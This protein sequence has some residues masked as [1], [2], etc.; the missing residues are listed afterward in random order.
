[1]IT[2]DEKF[3]ELRFWVFFKYI[4]WL[5]NH[6]CEGWNGWSE[7][8]CERSPRQPRIGSCSAF[9]YDLTHD[10]QQITVYRRW[11]RVILQDESAHAHN[12]CCEWCWLQLVLNI[13]FCICTKCNPD[14][15]GEMRK[16]STKSYNFFAWGKSLF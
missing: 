8:G 6:H 10:L 7:I 5:L 9:F 1:M 15:S 11:P 16:H 14:L 13:A 4:V 12:S 2:F 3:L